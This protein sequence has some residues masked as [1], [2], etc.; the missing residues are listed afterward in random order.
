ME[1]LSFYLSTIITMLLCVAT[2]YHSRKKFVSG[3]WKASESKNNITK[4]TLIWGVLGGTFIFHGLIWLFNQINIIS[5]V[6]HGEVLISASILNF[7]IGLIFAIVGR[8][9]VEWAPVK[10]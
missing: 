4:F 7:A 8:V 1:D 10:W 5:S 3:V 2:I 6:G 9:A